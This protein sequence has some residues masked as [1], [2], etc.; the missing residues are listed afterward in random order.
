[1]GVVRKS[2]LLTFGLALL[3]AVSLAG[4]VQAD[5]AQLLY[6]IGET[7]P[8]ISGGVFGWQPFET[9]RRYTSSAWLWIGFELPDI[10][11]DG[12]ISFRASKTGQPRFEYYGYYGTTAAKYDSSGTRTTL[13]FPPATDNVLEKLTPTAP[14]TQQ[15]RFSVTPETSFVYFKM[16]VSASRFSNTYVYG[17]DCTCIYTPAAG[18]APTV[19]SIDP[20][21]G[22]DDGPVS[23]TI[24]GTD[25]AN[26]ASASLQKDGETDIA[27]TSVTVVS[28]TEITCDFDLTGV[29]TGLWDVTVENP[30]AQSGTLP[31]GFEVIAA[32]TSPPTVEQ[33]SVAVTHGNGVGELKSAIGGGYVEPRNVA[34]DCLI[35]EF[36]EPIDAATIAPEDIS[37]VGV[38]NGDQS[39]L[40]DSV[41]LEGD[42]SIARI[43]LS[44][45]L[46]QPDRYT[47]TLADTVSDEAGNSLPFAAT[48]HF[49][50]LFGDANENLTVDV[51]DMLAVYSR[52]GQP[53]DLTTCHFDLDGSGIIDMNDALVARGHA[54]QSAPSTP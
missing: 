15:I 53:V 49:V 36:N 29:A 9:T 21:Q 16:Y 45:L 6:A 40:V 39:A 24:T 4:G 22:T 2:A 47:V 54:G 17:A 28:D 41:A 33:W 51:G 46:P 11:A 32:D 25:F 27:G 8:G 12:V 50:V 20:F 14:Y 19:T 18:A 13:S 23:V 34:I 48:A 38:T 35:V 10:G 30:D 7:D 5:E 44:G 26:G 52:I 42:G 43:T 3:A 31:D 37:I 1:M